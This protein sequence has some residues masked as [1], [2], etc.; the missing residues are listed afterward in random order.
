MS[1]EVSH[2]HNQHYYQSTDC[3][4]YPLLVGSTP[5]QI[6]LTN[7]FVTTA[8]LFCAYKLVYAQYKH[9]LLIGTSTKYFNKCSISLYLSFMQ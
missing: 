9:H 8:A 6:D 2:L 4:L 3:C 5:R 1:H 7:V